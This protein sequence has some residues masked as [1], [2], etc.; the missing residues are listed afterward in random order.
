[1][2]C[3]KAR[4]FRKGVH[5]TS[6]EN[7]AW[8]A[9]FNSVAGRPLAPQ[10][11]FVKHFEGVIEMTHGVFFSHGCALAPHITLFIVVDVSLGLG[12]ETHGPGET[13]EYALELIVSGPTVPRHSAHDMT[14]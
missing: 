6:S 11:R 10:W 14:G 9:T 8:H 3:G 5:E 1:M 4:I 12:S 2:I 7:I 13:Q